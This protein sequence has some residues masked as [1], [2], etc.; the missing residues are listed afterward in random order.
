MFKVVLVGHGD[1][2]KGFI[3]AVELIM[4]SQDDVYAVSLDASD[5]FESYMNSLEKFGNDNILY[6]ADL[7]GGTPSNVASYLTKQ[8]DVRCISGVNLALILEV[9]MMRLSDKSID[10]VFESVKLVIM[11][12][13][14][15]VEN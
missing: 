11:D 4:G 12:S 10:E 3:S 14:K 6:L 15:F 1:I 7:H 9:L 13:V 8:N 5:T 2:A